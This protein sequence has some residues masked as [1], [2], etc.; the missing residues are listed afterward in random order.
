MDSKVSTRR[1]SSESDARTGALAGRRVGLVVGQLTYGGAEGQLYELACRLADECAVVVYCLSDRSE[2]YGAKLEAAGIRVRILPARSNL[3]T[4][5]VLRLAHWLVRDRI[6]IAHAFL[7][8][9]SA[10]TYLATRL[11]PGIRLVT[12]ARNCKHEPSRLRRLV[13][14]RAFRASDAVLCNSRVM[15]AFAVE[16]YGAP[17]ARI[18]VVYNGVDIDRFAQPRTLGA[19]LVVGTIGRLEAQK[20]L[21]MFIDAAKCVLRSRRD[22]RFEIVGEGS[23]RA[24]MEE[25][26]HSSGLNGR[27]EFAGTTDDVP[28]RL[29]RWSQFW[30]TS[31][32][33]GTPNVVLEA[34]A[35]GVPVL[36]TDVGATRELIEDGR[37]GIL[38]PPSQPRALCDRSIELAVAPERARSMGEAARAAARE[39][40]SLE[41]MVDATRAIYGQVLARGRRG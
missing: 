1:T 21:G 9:A 25:R 2:P 38:L 36:A 16:H 5:R 30:L 37:T 20:N 11:I 34:M 23:L 19:N 14:R 35:S 8:I 3:D 29:A 17:A 32:W 41:T 39:R 12:S 26:V 31:D 10:Y 22:A 27:I 15:A 24:P 18:T 13:L 6:E 7:F 4:L 28:G 40:F 33:E